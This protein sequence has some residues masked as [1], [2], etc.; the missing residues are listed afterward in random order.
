LP[1]AIILVSTS[2]GVE[3]DALKSLK[4]TESV[5]EVFA[6]QGP[7]DIVVKAKAETFD[8]LRDI[9]AKIRR[10]LP[11]MQSMVTMLIIEATTLT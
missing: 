1:S 2:L 6:V 9:V 3:K 7:Y 8:K 5:E 4:S 10:T 11:K